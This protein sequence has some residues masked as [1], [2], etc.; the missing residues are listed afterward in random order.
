MS[1]IPEVYVLQ[2]TRKHLEQSKL[3]QDDMGA[4]FFEHTMY[5]VKDALT[6]ILALCDMEDMKQVPRVKKYIQRVT[7]LLNDV[8]FYQSGSH[9]NMNHVV[10]NVINVI[11]AHY[12]SS[13]NISYDLTNIKAYAKSDKNHLERMLLYVLIEAIESLNGQEVNLDIELSQKDK[14]AMIVFR[15]KKFHYA[16]V[17]LREIIE[18]HE[19]DAFKMQINSVDEN[20]EI[21]IRVP[22]SFDIKEADVIKSSNKKLKIGEL[23][24]VEKKEPEYARVV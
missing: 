12:K 3:L 16:S 15:I 20:T 10:I 22:L 5:D 6:S 2:A 8:R 17:A 4:H 21:I 18:F 14:D 23:R 1:N 24:K 11:K 19:K 7:G 9:F 13:V